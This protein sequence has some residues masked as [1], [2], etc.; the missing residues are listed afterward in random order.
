MPMPRKTK[1]VVL[2]S[3]RNLKLTSGEH[4]SALKWLQTVGVYALLLEIVLTGMQRR[5][6]GT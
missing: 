3:R 2:E 6:P 1:I 5:A 4:I